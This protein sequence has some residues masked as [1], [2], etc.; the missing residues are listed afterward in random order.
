[1]INQQILLG[2]NDRTVDSR[3]GVYTGELAGEIEPESA[4]FGSNT[5]A[6]TAFGDATGTDD[7][8]A[9]YANSIVQE[10]GKGARI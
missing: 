4:T 5:S 9:G 10:T 2:D 3:L 8:L 1:M 6:T 7:N